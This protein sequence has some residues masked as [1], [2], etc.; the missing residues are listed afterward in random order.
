MAIA[1]VMFTHSIWSKCRTT[2]HLGKEEKKGK[3]KRISKLYEQRRIRASKFGLT[4]GSSLCAAL[5]TLIS[6]PP[7][8]CYDDF[9]RS[10]SLAGFRFQPVTHQC[11]SS[12]M[13]MR[14]LYLPLLSKMFDKPT[15]LSNGDGNGGLTRRGEYVIMMMKLCPC[16]GGWL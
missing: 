6:A 1:Q 3:K 7:V 14:L 15:M 10:C 9:S 11:R 13:P 4:S 8:H 16:D 5:P 12:S 2:I